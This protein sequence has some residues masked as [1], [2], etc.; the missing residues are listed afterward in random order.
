MG[1]LYRKNHWRYRGLG[2]KVQ[3][4]RLFFDGFRFEV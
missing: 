4:V 3:G 1:I 2:L